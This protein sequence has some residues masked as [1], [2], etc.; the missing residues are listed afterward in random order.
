MFLLNATLGHILYLSGSFR[1]GWFVHAV[2][3]EDM[4]H[5]YDIFR[6]HHVSVGCHTGAYP[7]S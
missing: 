6:L 4:R 7:S 1:G 5:C 3:I 2:L